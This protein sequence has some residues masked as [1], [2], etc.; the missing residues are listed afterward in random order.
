MLTVKCK[1]LFS[2]FFLFSLT[3]NSIIKNLSNKGQGKIT[4]D[5]EYQPGIALVT[6]DNPER[7]NALSAK[8]MVEFHHVVNQLERND[9]DIVAVIVKGG[10]SPMK[11]FCSGLGT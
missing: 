11:S 3:M 8:M 7:H 2:P 6:I 4:L 9:K 1:Y 5:L 10:G